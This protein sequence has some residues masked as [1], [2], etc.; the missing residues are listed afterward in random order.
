LRAAAFHFWPFFS[1]QAQS[2]EDWDET[3]S[4]S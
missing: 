4:K 1:A 2:E 3:H